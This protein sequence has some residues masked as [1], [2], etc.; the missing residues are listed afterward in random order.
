MSFAKASAVLQPVSSLN[1]FV[2]LELRTFVPDHVVAIKLFCYSEGISWSSN[3]SP[4][5]PV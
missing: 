2:I 4:V 5:F 3:L 1:L